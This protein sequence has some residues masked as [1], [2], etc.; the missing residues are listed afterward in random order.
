[1]QTENVGFLTKHLN[2]GASLDQT[3]RNG[4][5]EVGIGADTSVIS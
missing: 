2:D 3:A 5:S 4:R 1:M